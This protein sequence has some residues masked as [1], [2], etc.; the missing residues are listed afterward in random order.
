VIVRAKVLTERGLEYGDDVKRNVTITKGSA[1][2]QLGWIYTCGRHSTCVLSFSLI[3]TVSTS[4]IKILEG[5]LAAL[6]HANIG[7][8]AAVSPFAILQLLGTAPW[9]LA[10]TGA[11]TGA[12]GCFLH[13]LWNLW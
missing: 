7:N 8:V 10:I 3:L 1:H 2:R 11:L 13:H 9:L 12:A 4:D 5:S 6:L